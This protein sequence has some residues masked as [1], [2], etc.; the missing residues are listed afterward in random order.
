VS[1]PDCRRLSAPSVIPAAKRQT[2][3]AA[4]ADGW[5]N[6]PDLCPECTRAFMLALDGI[7]GPPLRWHPNFAARAE[8]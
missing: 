2:C 4:L 3:I 7:A 8:R 1:G 5:I 6:P